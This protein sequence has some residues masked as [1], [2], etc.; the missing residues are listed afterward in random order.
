MRSNNN[1]S[2]LLPGRSLQVFMGLFCNLWI[3][4]FMI[5]CDKHVGE[6]YEQKIDYNRYRHTE[7]HHV[8]YHVNLR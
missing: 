4:R 5:L 7:H 2:M 6:I 1:L 8:L 3:F